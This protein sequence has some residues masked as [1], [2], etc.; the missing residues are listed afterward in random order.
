MAPQ[1]HSAVLQDSDKAALLRL[2]RETILRRLRDEP[3]PALPCGSTLEQRCGA[4]VS[5]HRKGTLRGC[6]GLVMPV[7]P[8]NEVI[9]EM[10]LSAAFGDPRFK[11]LRE[12][13]LADLDIEISVLTPLQ[14][15]DDPAMID[16]GRHGLMI[17]KGRHSGLLLPQVAI[18]YGWDREAFLDNTCLKAGLEPGAWRDPDATIYTFA[19]DVF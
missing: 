3:L 10:A 6:I 2:A 4:F 12:E 15:I 11:P 1:E 7:K 5:L 9:R 13:E 8:L 17:V 18:E 16:V 14:Q 19:A